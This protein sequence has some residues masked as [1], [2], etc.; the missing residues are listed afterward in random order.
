M[1][2]TISDSELL[3]RMGERD[4]HAVAALYDRYAGMLLALALRILRDGG[5]IAVQLLPA[6]ELVVHLERRGSATVSRLTR[7]RR[8]HADA[9]AL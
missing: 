3:R 2:S 1:T 5:W 4:P 9:W 7:N 6:D 8:Q